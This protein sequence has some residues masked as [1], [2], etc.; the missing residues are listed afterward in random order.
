MR[1]AT[2]VEPNLVLRP[3]SWSAASA[4]ELLLGAL[5]LGLVVEVLREDEHGEDDEARGDGDD[6]RGVPLAD[7]VEAV[8]PLDRGAGRDRGVSAFHIVPFLNGH[9]VLP[10]RRG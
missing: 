5:D 3:A 6:R 10:I 8:D 1:G 4:V 9:L 7:L 2:G